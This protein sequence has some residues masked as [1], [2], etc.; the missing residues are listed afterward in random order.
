MYTFAKYVISD[1]TL[2]NSITHYFEWQEPMV[3]SRV[4]LLKL[5]VLREYKSRSPISILIEQGLNGLIAHM[6]L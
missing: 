1:Q 6:N 5:P 3:S 2:D 4:E